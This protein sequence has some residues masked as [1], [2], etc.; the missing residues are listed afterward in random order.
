MRQF[1]ITNETLPNMEAADGLRF[2]PPL[3]PHDVRRTRNLTW[4]IVSAMD[5]EQIKKLIDDPELFPGIHNYCD[6]WCE[7][8]PLTKRC[9]VFAMEQAESTDPSTHDPENEAFWLRLKGTFNATLEL[10]E[11]IA[12][13]AGVDIDTLAPEEDAAIESLI[14]RETGE[15][16]LVRVAMEYMRLVGEWFEQ[17]DGQTGD[18]AKEAGQ[19]SK[20]AELKDIEQVIL[21]YHAFICV[22]LRRAVQQEFRGRPAWLNDMPKD[23]DGSAKIALTAI[24]RSIAAW[25][26]MRAYF[27]RRKERLLNLL[28]RLERLRRGTERAFPNARAFVRP[29]F[30]E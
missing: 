5:K 26:R 17:A 25:W 18:I 30:D 22:K 23:S 2:A 10:L 7:R 8:C 13:E 4:V 9:A 24:D 1:G 21:W 27:P 15:H 28:V 12:Q 20:A 3:R 16:E 19:E 6:R 29:G 11:E 14:D